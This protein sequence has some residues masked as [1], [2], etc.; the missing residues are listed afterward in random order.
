MRSL[1]ITLPL[2]AAVGCWTPTGQVVPPPP[3]PTVVIPAVGEVASARLKSIGS[4]LGEAYDATLTKEADIAALINWLNGIDWSP[5]RAGDLWNVGLAEVGQITVK[6]KDGTARQ[7]GLSG[8]MVIVNRWEW[9]ADTT[10]LA[11]L[12]KRATPAKGP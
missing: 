12:A 7:F 1:L 5:A 3:P 4:S 8:G 11:E 10:K 6:L 2:L 9:R